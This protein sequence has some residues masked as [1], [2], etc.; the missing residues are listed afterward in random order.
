MTIP[1]LP[2]FS[3]GFFTKKCQDAQEIVLLWDKVGGMAPMTPPGSTTEPADWQTHGGTCDAPLCPISFI[4]M[5][6]FFSK[7]WPNNRLAPLQSL[8]VGVPPRPLS[9]KYWIATAVVCNVFLF[10]LVKYSVNPQAKEHI[11]FSTSVRICLKKSLL[12]V[13]HS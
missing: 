9:G 8:R 3:E 5:H 11:A 1:F 7:I 12:Q 4:F 6:F 2:I 10:T 13:D